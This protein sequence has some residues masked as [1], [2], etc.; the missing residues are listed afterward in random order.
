ML[1]WG[2]RGRV[3]G[4]PVVWSGDGE[5][6]G[7]AGRRDGSGEPA[8]NTVDSAF[9]DAEAESSDGNA[10]ALVRCAGVLFGCDASSE[11][12]GRL[13]SR[14]GTSTS[15]TRGT[16]PTWSPD[17]K[18][19]AFMDNVAHDVGLSDF[20]PMARAWYQPDPPSGCAI[21]AAM[22]AGRQPS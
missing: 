7:N 18:T 4:G 16:E 10:V 22:V 9:L 2:V 11:I 8:S 20:A 5:H 19:I 6:R 13:H 17:G 3:H 15:L 1:T 21:E 12:V 14:A